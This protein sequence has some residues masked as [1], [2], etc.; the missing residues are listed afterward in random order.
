MTPNEIAIEQSA[1]QIR[2][3]GEYTEEVEVVKN[4]KTEKQ[5]AARK[6]YQK[7]YLNKNRAKILEYQRDYRKSH[8]AE[9]VITQKKWR[10]SKL[11]N[12]KT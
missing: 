2:M 5:I 8:K 7:T 12:T 6:R 9:R 1:Y 4:P 10:G 11:I 3:Q